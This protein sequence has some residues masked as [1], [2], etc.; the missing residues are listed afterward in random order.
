M[1]RK[2]E[3]TVDNFENRNSTRIN[4]TS[5]LEVKDLQSGNI[6]NAKMFNYSRE[7]VYF[8]SD[9]VL[10]PGMQVYIGI[11]NSP[12]ASLPD[13]LEYYRAEIMWR[14]KLK[15]SSYRF[16]YGIKLES[17]NNKQNLK[18]NDTKKTKNL[19]KHPRKPYKQATMF[20]TKNGIF[21]GTIKNISSCGVFI[22]SKKPF[23]VGQ[24]LTLARQYKNG[25][26]VKIKG[27]IVWTDDDGFGVKF[28]S[29]DEK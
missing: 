10:N 25:E 6:H 14:K 21:E 11:Q 13:V 18:S 7:G 27:Q 28:L 2:V 29:V 9:S 26:H 23:E 24:I 3:R 4:H 15:R 20:S 12:Y 19:R 5:S 22:M 8:E 17:L 16:G 1:K